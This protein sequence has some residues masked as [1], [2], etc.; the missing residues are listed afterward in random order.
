MVVEVIKSI[1]D[2]ASNII[3]SISDCG[4]YSQAQSLFLVTTEKIQ[5]YAGCVNKENYKPTPFN[6]ESLPLGLRLCCCVTFDAQ[7]IYVH[8]YVKPSAR[9]R[10]RHHST[11]QET[12]KNLK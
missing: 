12:T 1:Q 10:R 4:V 6:V 8:M 5:R 7:Q 2:C 9:G 3:K 11:I